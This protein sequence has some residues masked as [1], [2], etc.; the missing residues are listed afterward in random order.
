MIRWSKILSAQMRV[1]VGRFD[2]KHAVSQLQNGNVKRAAA[3]SNTAI[4][5]SFFLSRP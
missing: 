3:Q 5:S 1:A 2:F 4:F